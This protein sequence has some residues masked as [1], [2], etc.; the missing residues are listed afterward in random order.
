MERDPMVRL[1]SPA[2]L[3]VVPVVLNPMAGGAGA[4]AAD[5]IR[6]ALAAEGLGSSVQLVAPHEV[7]AAAWAAARR[8][9]LVAVAG[10]DGTLSAAAAALAGT[11]ALLLPVPAGTRN[12]FSRRLGI[13][14]AEA[15]ATA[16]A[17][18]MVIRV[19]VA[20]VAERA[21]IHH[22]SA[23]L[24]PRIVRDRAGLPGWLGK[25][26]ATAVATL[27][28]LLRLRTTTVSIE[29]R[30]GVQREREVTGL[31]VG[32]GAGS[33]RLPVDHHVANG[34]SLEVVVSPART[35]TGLVLEAGR[36]LRRLRRGESLRHAG[37]EVL[38]APG[39]TLSAEHPIDVALDGEVR[40][41]EPPLAFRIQPRALRV[42]SLPREEVPDAERG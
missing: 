5:R 14:T 39:F 17:R 28:V 41:V 24:Y 23:G 21:F 34:D 19:P 10:G 32:L 3:S 22:A 16:I 4:A 7:G 11:D 1:E 20:W 30:G 33:F 6:D 15:A 27:W 9:G 35:R 37:L 36:A 18:G 13:A 42:L 29:T 25:H 2:S 38:H 31:W 26:A 12:H 8:S 40:R